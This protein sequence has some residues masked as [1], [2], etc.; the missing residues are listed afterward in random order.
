MSFERGACQ[1]DYDRGIY[2]RRIEFNDVR[3]MFLRLW[4]VT[5]GVE[6]F[7]HEAALDDFYRRRGMMK[8]RKC[9]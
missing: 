1:Q 8:R 7:L 5:Y 3:P 6:H 2:R 4:E 9:R